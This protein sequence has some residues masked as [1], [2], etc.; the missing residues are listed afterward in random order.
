[1]DDGDAAACL[2][3]LQYIHNNKNK[4]WPDVYNGIWLCLFVF[5]FARRRN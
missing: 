3:A 4:A 5:L 1:M 2:A